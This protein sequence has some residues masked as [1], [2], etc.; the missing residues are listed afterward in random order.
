MTK[1]GSRRFRTA[2]LGTPVLPPGWL[3]RT[4]LRLRALL[5]RAHRSMAPP[6]LQVLE[7]LLSILD[8]RA[9]ALLVDLGVPDLLHVPRTI[10]ELA[11]ATGTDM[12]NLQRLLRYSASRGLVRLDGHGQYRSSPLVQAL[13]SD[14]VNPWT[15]WVLMAGSDWFWNALQH[16]DAPLHNPSVSG[17]KSAS[18][19]EF[20]EFVNKVR[21]DA[22]IA[23]NT[24][25]E[26]GST[27]QS[28]VLTHGLRWSETRSVCDVGGG[29]GAALEV[30]LRVHP[31]LEAT[32]FDL[33]EVVDKT[34]PALRS[35]PLASR[36]QIVGGDFFNSVP[37]GADRYLMLRVVNEW[38]DKHALTILRAVT[39]A[40]RPDGHVLVVE[41]VLPEKPR[42]E[43]VFASDF[44][45]L[46]LL[47]RERT[48]SEYQSLFKSAGLQINRVTLLAT[49]ATAFELKGLAPSTDV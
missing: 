30:L 20:H 14:Q 32:L 47:G 36:C 16:L 8:N 22:G 29:T 44:M 33:P 45:K 1:S 17:I 3:T 23:F 49:G 28:I 6:S 19:H 34:R 2:V 11:D 21:P 4:V 35:G 41:H 40:M 38:D 42:N 31:H 9:L 26:A 7:T 24:A 15:G 48:T 12:T 18:G 46:A 37:S 39:D 10:N 13:R 25:M 27:I 5:N 43:L